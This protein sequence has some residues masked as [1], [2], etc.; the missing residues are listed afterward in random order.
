[1]E[2]LQLHYYLENNSH[3]MN[4][5]IKNKAELELLRLLNHV[6]KTLKYDLEF[7]IE[8][9]EEG[10]ILERIRIINKKKG[11]TYVLA[12]S[13]FGSIFTTILTNVI[14]DYISKNKKLENLQIEVLEKESIKLDY[15][16]KKLKEADYKDEDSLKK[17]ILFLL[18]DGKVK[19]LKSNFYEFLDNEQKITQISTLELD[20]NNEPISE[21]KI[22]EKSKFKR[23]VEKEIELE[24]KVISNSEVE[25]IS[26]VFKKGNDNWKGI[27]NGEPIEFK[28]GDL[29]FKK[30][31]LD[32]QVSFTTGTKILCELEIKIVL[33]KK[34]DPKVKSRYAYDIVV[35]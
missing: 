3:A 22:V 25:I 26:P 1:M 15:E 30:K 32:R 5:F 23:F 19:V 10:G 14:S 20:N 33:D 8:A 27:L 17:V 31:V 9:L 35:K 11:K 29:E 21:E 16:I 4:A 12:L 18:M 28:I 13:I 24:P 34:G 2:K 6:S 7:E